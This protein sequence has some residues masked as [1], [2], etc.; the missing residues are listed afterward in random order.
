M[1]SRR[2]A[3]VNASAAIRNAKSFETVELWRP[4]A[5]RER[6]GKKNFEPLSLAVDD[7]HHS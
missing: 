6:L 3:E 5:N 4:A 2:V 7:I 1:V